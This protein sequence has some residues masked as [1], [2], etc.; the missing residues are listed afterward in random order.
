M[1]DIDDILKRFEKDIA[2]I[3]KL[4]KSLLRV[5]KDDNTIDIEKLQKQVS[6]YLK[7]QIRGTRDGR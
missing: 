3:T 7:K 6:K 5:R 4:G 2:D 1:S